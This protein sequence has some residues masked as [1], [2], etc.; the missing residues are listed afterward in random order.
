MSKSNKRVIV[1]GAGIAGLATAI[2]LALQE[3]TVIVYEKNDYPGGK[4]HAFEQDGFHFD[5]GPSL[6]TQPQ[7]IEEL[8]AAAGE[9]TAD[10]L[11]Y[12]KEEATCNYFYEDGTR[13]TTYADREKLKAAVANLD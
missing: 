8:F 1:I 4:L 2:R 9:P 3:M 6:F 12:R 13:L 10:Y 7:L 5:A 11:Q